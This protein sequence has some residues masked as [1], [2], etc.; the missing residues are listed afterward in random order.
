VSY[1]ID[2]ALTEMRRLL[3]AGE[4]EEQQF[5]MLK[6]KGVLD[7]LGFTVSEPD[8]TIVG[9]PL[10]ISVPQPQASPSVADELLKLKNLVDMGVLTQEEFDRKKSK[11][12]GE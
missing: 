3:D 2:P 5:N 1:K 10:E 8:A 11:L 7:A 9:A 4:L 12:L 6:E